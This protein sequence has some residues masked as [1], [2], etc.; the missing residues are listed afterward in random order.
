MDDRRWARAHGL[1]TNNS[2]LLLYNEQAS[3]NS[4]KKIQVE[5]VWKPS[6]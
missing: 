1:T 3:A 2:K 6:F 5:N 4:F